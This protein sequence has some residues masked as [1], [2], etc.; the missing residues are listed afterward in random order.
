MLYKNGDAM[1]LKPKAVETLIALVERAGEIVS[2]EQLMKR[3]WADSFVEEANLTQNIYLLRRTLGKMPNGKPL[4]ETFWRR[5]YRFNGAIYEASSGANDS[6][7]IRGISSGKPLATSGSN[8]KHLVFSIAAG[9]FF[10]LIGLAAIEVLFTPKPPFQQSKDANSVLKIARLIPDLNIL[11]STFA[12]DGTHL[13]Y[14]LSDNGKWSVWL[15]DLTTGGTVQI[16]PA[17]EDGYYSLNFSSDGKILFYATSLK[18]APNG[19]ILRKNLADG[20]TQNITSNVINDFALSPDEKQIAFIND[21]GKL[22]L[23]QTDGSGERILSE[24]DG[25]NSWFAAWGS[26]MSWSPDGTR[27]ALC[28]FVRDEQGRAKPQLIEISTRD[29]SERVIAGPDLNY[30][31]DALWLSDGSAILVIARETETA[32][33]QIW[34]VAYPSGEM[35][36]V[37]NDINSYDD[38]ALSPNSSQLVAQ[39]QFDNMNLWSGS[40]GASE[41]F[42]QLTF[43]NAAGD[44]RN[45][46]VFTPDGKIIYTSP[47]DG[48]VDLWQMNADGSQQ[49][50]LTK[51]AGEYNGRP[52]VTPDGHFIVFS[53]SRSGKNQIWRMEA[54]GG[55]PQQLINSDYPAIQPSL[56]PDGKLVFFKLEDDSDSI[57]K[58]SIDGGKALRVAKADHVWSP[59]VSPDGKLIAYQFYDEGSAKPWKV[60]IMSAESGETVKTFDVFCFRHLTAWTSDT[61]SLIYISNDQKNLWQL[62]IDSGKPRQL[63]N[64][65]S[66]QINYFAFSTDY[67]RVLLSRGNPS[68]EVVLLDNF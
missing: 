67:K 55:N 22:L 66:G 2:K 23:A 49:K 62:P 24:R 40:L 1:P 20:T 51:N 36:R 18:G 8:K 28:G 44:G 11:D 57:W 4:I 26:K 15:K 27:I 19:T 43:G 60:G 53:S 48:H 45:G 9:V 58:V 10:L 25:K 41:S 3:L 33:F 6:V 46:I 42:R 5:G 50:Q 21:K 37:S 56:S 14:I 7:Y 17:S 64:F 16:L 65:E 31:E 59:A 52:S 39:Q 68:R 35:T 61:K 12:P 30:M 54:D 29:G 47:R 32:P 63:T 38:I 34:R 13:A